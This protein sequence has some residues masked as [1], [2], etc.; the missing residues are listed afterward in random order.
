M[1]TFRACKGTY[2]NNAGAVSL[3][4]NTDIADNDK[5]AG[6]E[7]RSFPAG[8]RSG[9]HTKGD[10]CLMG[11]SAKENGRYEVNK[12]SEMLEIQREMYVE[13]IILQLVHKK[14][15]MEDLVAIIQG[16]LMEDCGCGNSEL[17][18]AFCGPDVR[19]GRSSQDP[20]RAEVWKVQKM[21]TV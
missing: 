4:I 15:V 21:Q 13:R 8:E 20:S 14:V 16:I 12:R 3:E 11:N 5:T 2:S 19:V 6:F 17:Q 1:L 10:G 9:I 7:L 18:R